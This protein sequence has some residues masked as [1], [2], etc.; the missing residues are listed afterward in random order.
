M[1]G[2]EAVLMEGGIPTFEHMRPQ[3]E[4][5]LVG[6]YL[7]AR[8]FASGHIKNGGYN[9]MTAGDLLSLPVR[10]Q[11]MQ[12]RFGGSGVPFAEANKNIRNLLQD[13]NG[14]ES[15]SLVFRL[16]ERQAKDFNTLFNTHKKR[17]GLPNYEDL[18]RQGE[19]I[20]VSGDG[21]ISGPFE[22]RLNRYL[23][24]SVESK[25]RGIGTTEVDY[26]KNHRERIAVERGLAQEILDPMIG[27]NYRDII[28]RAK[29][30]VYEN[31]TESSINTLSDLVRFL[32][33]NQLTAMEKI[34]PE[35]KYR[36]YTVTNGER[37]I[38]KELGYQ[39][40]RVAEVNLRTPKDGL[41]SWVV[42]GIEKLIDARK[43]AVSEMNAKD[44]IN[45]QD[46]DFDLDKSGSFFATP[47][48]V[49]KE[50]HSV[51]GYHEISSEQIWEKASYEL[52]LE[53]GAEIGSYIT[54]LKSLESARPNIVRQHSLTS[55]L[56]QFFGA[57]D[58]IQKF[59]KLEPGY[60]RGVTRDA[61]T[62][63]VFRTSESVP[64][65]NVMGEVKVGTQTY[66]VEFRHGAEFVDAIGHM[67][68]VIKHTIDTYGDLAQLNERNVRDLFWF[69]ED[70][71]LL[72]LVRKDAQGRREVVSWNSNALPEI[73]A[74][75]GRINKNVLQALLGV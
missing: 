17:E 39:A 72:R 34:S 67:K 43:G 23:A 7:G 50:I 33:G 56:Y 21:N 52:S 75:K 5:A 35:Y 48:K 62:G 12:L 22:G 30:E 58:G 64:G 25:T 42:T 9:V 16:S 20:I 69:S 63:E 26:I 57:Q 54:E 41:N 11:G 6:N 2:L 53:N 68:K 1:T 73:G 70:V 19:E 49:L 24:A 18:F 4:R 28:E 61:T 31:T 47:G 32:D 8:N 29:N 45:P 44:L 13:P 10:E 27:K 74:M 66:S 60:R 65:V 38:A 15:I 14:V 40:V 46:A 36:D 51:A 37:S 71:G 59:N 3:I 55:L